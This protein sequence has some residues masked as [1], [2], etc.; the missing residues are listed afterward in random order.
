MSVAG[1]TTIVGDYESS[2]QLLSSDSKGKA[3]IPSEATHFDTL[4]PSFSQVSPSTLVSLPCEP[5]H[6]L[7]QQTQPTQDLVTI[8]Q[9]RPFFVTIDKTG[10]LG[11]LKKLDQQL[12]DAGEASIFSRKEPVAWLGH[13][14]TPG[15]LGLIN[16]GGLPKLLTK[17]R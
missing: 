11:A 12:L 7:P 6:N 15:T 8:E 10:V 1:A 5:T 4:K 14:L 3:R 2:A 17:V 16:H 13:E 9:E